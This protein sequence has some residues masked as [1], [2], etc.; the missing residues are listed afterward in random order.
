MQILKTVKFIIIGIIIKAILFLV[1]TP[2]YAMRRHLVDSWDLTMLIISS[3]IVIVSIINRKSKNNGISGNEKI[4]LNKRIKGFIYCTSFSMYIPFF[5]LSYKGDNIV[6]YAV[7][8]EFW[9][10]LIVVEMVM[11]AR[12]RNAINELAKLNVSDNYIVII[13]N[14]IVSRPATYNISSLTSK[15]EN[16]ITIIDDFIFVP[17]YIAQFFVDKIYDS[18]EVYYAG[19]KEKLLKIFESSK[20]KVMITRK[21]IQIS[22]ELV[23]LVSKV[24]GG[25]AF[26]AQ[27]DVINS[28]D[29]KFSDKK[30]RSIEVSSTWPKDF[31]RE[32]NDNHVELSDKRALRDVATY[33]GE[34]EV[35]RAICRLISNEGEFRTDIEYFYDLLKIAQLIIHYWGLMCYEESGSDYLEYKGAISIGEFNSSIIDKGDGKYA[36][37]A[38]YKAAVDYIYK[39][40]AGINSNFSSKKPTLSGRA[41][42][43]IARNRIVGHGAFAYSISEDVIVA[44]NR[45]I[46]GILDSFL[47]ENHIDDTNN[48]VN[49]CIEKV[50]FQ[51]DDIYL[52]NAVYNE[53][54]YQY[55]SYFT[56]KIL[57]FGNGLNVT[58][59]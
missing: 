27:N 25:D 54:N 29:K 20:G 28:I 48:L 21:L 5:V 59:K 26:D 14:S 9:I 51:D 37:G 58:L 56:G 18:K 6:V 43:V 12:L 22:R 31:I 23:V 19:R 17:E 8:I 3:I 52:L 49:E 33:E 57:T 35:K 39:E 40:V 2:S 1:R 13:Q 53:E 46:I 24:Y 32:I 10:I 30:V 38:D 41:A 45:I 16:K 15:I 55:I 34:N 47:H 44:L 7:A 50:K 42:I 36:M 4:E 11:S